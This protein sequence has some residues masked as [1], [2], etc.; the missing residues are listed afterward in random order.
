MDITYINNISSLIY[1]IRYFDG[2]FIFNLFFF[3][4]ILFIRNLFLFLRSQRIKDLSDI[5]LLLR[6]S[7]L[8]HLFDDFLCW[9]NL[10]FQCFFDVKAEIRIRHYHNT[11]IVLS[12]LLLTIAYLKYL[13]QFIEIEVFI[14]DNKGCLSIADN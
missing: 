1:S 2:S 12:L 11:H 10:V 6:I 13:C 14:E 7:L 5:R 9:S 8:H 3:L 4:F